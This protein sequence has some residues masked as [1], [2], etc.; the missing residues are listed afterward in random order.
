MQTIILDGVQVFF[1]YSLAVLIF[2]FSSLGAGLLVTSFAIG[3]KISFPRRFLMAFSIGGI[4]LALAT[5]TLMLLGYF[6]PVF[7]EPSSFILLLLLFGVV[8]KHVSKCGGLF[9]SRAFYYAAISLFLLL[10][11]RLAF[12]KY[13]LL[14]G[15]SDSPVHYQIVESFLHPENPAVSQLSFETIFQHYYH[16]GFHSLVA[17][18]SLVSGISPTNAISLIG[19]FFLVIAPLSL[20]YFFITFIHNPKGAFF[21]ALLA[22]IGWHM[23][24]FAV[25]W[26]KFPALTAL[27]LFPA[28]V[29][30]IAQV[31]SK[32]QKTKNIFILSVL[33]ISITLIHTRILIILALALAAHITVEKIHADTKLSPARSLIYTFLAIAIL[34]PFLVLMQYFYAQRLILGMVAILLPFAFYEHSR[35]S[36]KVIIY[37]A[38]LWLLALLPD[39]GIDLVLLNRQFLEMILYI[40]LSLLGGIGLI[41]FFK[42]LSFPDSLFLCPCHLPRNSLMDIPMSFIPDQCF[43][44]KS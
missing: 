25:N 26:G 38:F 23:P 27:A 24:A 5:Y 29:A 43:L 8:L 39:L 41:A 32:K 14:P 28:L 42:R 1:A 10:F 31:L 44:Q 11:L 2:F 30:F 37:I 9:K 7:F 4:P 12:L 19:Q 18:L 20:F 6:F 17:W 40:P 3:E 16:F 21:A 35:I 36:L 15:Y 22:A 34:S 13:L 33:I